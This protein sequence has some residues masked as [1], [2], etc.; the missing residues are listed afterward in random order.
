MEQA[1]RDSRN[2]ELLRSARREARGGGARGGP[3]GEEV[4]G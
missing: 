4:G 2:K 1:W 3:A